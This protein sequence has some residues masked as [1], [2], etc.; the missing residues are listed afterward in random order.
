M[1]ESPTFFQAFGPSLESLKKAKT[2]GK[3]LF[4]VIDN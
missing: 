1:A 4:F 2:S 3:F